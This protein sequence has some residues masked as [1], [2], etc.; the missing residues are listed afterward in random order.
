MNSTAAM[1]PFTRATGRMTKKKG[2]ATCP[3]PMATSTR[4][5]GLTTKCK[6]KV[7][8]SHKLEIGIVDI[9]RMG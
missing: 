1:G 8:Y 9:F 5:T 7:N 4:E 3:L 6:A 2:L